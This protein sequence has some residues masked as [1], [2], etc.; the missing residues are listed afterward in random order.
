MKRGQ[1]HKKQCG[2]GDFWR[3]VIEQSGSGAPRHCGTTAETMNCFHDDILL[4]AVAQNSA[5]RVNQRAVLERFNADVTDVRR[6]LLQMFRRPIFPRPIPKLQTCFDEEFRQ[7]AFLSD[8]VVAFAFAV[9]VLNI[10]AYTSAQITIW[11]R[12]TTKFFFHHEGNAILRAIVHALLKI[13]EFAIFY[14]VEAVAREDMPIIGDRVDNFAGAAPLDNEPIL[15]KRSEQEA[16]S[17]V[18]RL[19]ASVERFKISCVRRV[20]H[21]IEGSLILGSQLRQVTISQ[22]EVRFLCGA[23]WL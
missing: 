10:L 6:Q 17:I 2:F 14:A 11:T 8:N 21:V 22:R 1:F 5:G 18:E 7:F 13:T 3:D 15:P 4:S 23:D 20:H 9:E 19:K 16:T 12:D